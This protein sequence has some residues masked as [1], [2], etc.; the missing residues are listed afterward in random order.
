[1]PMRSLAVG[2]L[3]LE[4]ASVA[5]R[6]TPAVSTC[7]QHSLVPQVQPL[8]DPA[9][10]IPFQVPGSSD[11]LS[12]P[13]GLP[14]TGQK[15]VLTGGHAACPQSLPRHETAV[16]TH[17]LGL[18]HMAAPTCRQAVWCQGH[19][20]GEWIAAWT[21]SSSN[22]GCQSLMEGLNAY[23]VTCVSCIQAAVPGLMM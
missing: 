18:A 6:D 9:G 12:Q 20:P 7:T 11:A 15:R 3:L 4:A 19:R 14:Q 21:K 1:M 13:G 5:A 23:R 16:A 22:A 2:V 17:E 10:T 8:P